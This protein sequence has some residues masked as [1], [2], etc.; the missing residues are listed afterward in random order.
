MELKEGK[1]CKN[2]RIITGV[3]GEGDKGEWRQEKWGGRTGENCSEVEITK[4][5]K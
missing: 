2:S 3:V 4:N 5:R 1:K